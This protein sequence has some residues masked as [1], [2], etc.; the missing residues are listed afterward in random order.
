MFEGEFDVI[1]VL[2]RLP[3]LQDLSLSDLKADSETLHASTTS[4]L[5]YSPASPQQLWSAQDDWTG[6]SRRRLTDAGMQLLCT[7]TSVRALHL[8]SVQDVTAAGLAALQDQPELNSMELED[9]TC[10]F[11]LSDVP[12][13][14]KLT[15]LT[16]MQLCW[17]LDNHGAEFDPMVL[18]HMMHLKELGLDC[19][20]AAGGAAG[21]AE[22]LSRL[23]Q[24]PALEALQLGHVH[25][26]NE[27]PP[28]AF[29]Q[30]VSS[31][32]LRSFNWSDIR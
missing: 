14:S 24:L 18:T 17:V 28:V 25:G 20:T 6:Y 32:A 5:Q 23:S 11:T 22:L 26:L 29:S 7:L 12:A 2:M 4:V 16:R 8:G 15:A 30:L 21:A 27:V 10:D 13:L 19:C 9:L 31:S 1:A 3:V